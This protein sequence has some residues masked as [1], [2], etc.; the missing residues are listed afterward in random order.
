LLQRG[1]YPID[2]D[3][4]VFVN[5]SKGNHI[6]AVVYV[7]DLRLF[8]KDIISIDNLKKNLYK[9]FQITDL[10]AIK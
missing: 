5:D 9:R 1:L 3:H 2:T 8:G 7:N 6:M 4:S 10:G